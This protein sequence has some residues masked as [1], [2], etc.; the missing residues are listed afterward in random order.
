M[1]ERSKQR[2][3]RIAGRKGKNGERGAALVLT[4]IMLVLM[5]VIA[6]SVIA[7]SNSEAIVAGNDLQQTRARYA[8]I[9]GLEYMTNQFSDLFVRTSNPTAA[10]LN[11][12][13][14]TP[15]PGFVAEGYVFDQTLKVGDRPARYE[16]LP[17]D[18]R[19]YAGLYASLV[20]YKLT[21]IATHE[22]TG[23]RVTVEREINNYLIPLFQFGMFSDSDIELHP[24]PP[25]LF[26]GRVH[27]NG[28]IYVNGDVRF[29]SKVTTASE[30]VRDV[31]RNGSTR[32]GGNVRM[33]V[34]GTNVQLTRGSATNGPNFPG[35]ANGQRGYW[36]GS[37]AGNAFN[38]WDNTSI[39]P[40]TG[41]DNQ[42]NKQLLTRSTGAVPLRLPLELDGNPTREIIKRRLTGDDQTLTESR[43]H[44]K[45]QIRILLDDENI[46]GT[47][48]A[49]IPAGRGVTLS[50]F[51]PVPLGGGKSLWRID[52]NGN[53]VTTS[54]TAPKQG[55]VSGPMAN[56]VRNAKSTSSTSGSVTIPRGAGINGRILIEIVP[57]N[58]APIDVTSLALSMGMTVGEPN[59]I[60]HLQRPL[61]AAFTQG[62]RDRD[63]ESDDLVSLINS[64]MAA[65]GEIQVSST[66]PVS[67][68]TYGFLDNI[69]DDASFR[70]D[71]PVPVSTP[72]PANLNAIVPINVYNVR[73]GWPRT[74]LPINIINERGMTSVVEINMRNL[75]RWVDGVYDNN[76][77]AGTQAVS[78]NIDGQNGYVLYISDRR[79]DKIKQELNA[80]NATISTTNGMVDN[81]D[82]Y[83]P[84]GSL[85]AGEDV[86]D[87]GRDFGTGQ[88]KRGSLQKDTT[89][90]PDLGNTWSVSGTVNLVNRRNRAITNVLTWSNPNNYFRRAVRLFNGE[91]LQ[92]SGTGEKLSA[93]KGL[94]VATENM[95]YIWGNFNTT[96]INSA[97]ASGTASLNDSTRPSYYLGNQVPASIISDAFFPLSRT[98]YDGASAMF[99]EGG[100]TRPADGNLQNV[101]Q[102]TSVRAGIIAGNNLSAL[103]GSPDAGN[104]ADSRLSGGM[105]NF[106]RF[107]ENWVNTNRRW[108]FVGSFIPLYR[109]TQALGQWN[110]AAVSGTQFI[111]Y[112][113]PVRNWAFDDTFKN[114]AQLPPGTPVFQY[115]EPTGF[116]QVLNH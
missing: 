115:V 29:L 85:D 96:G 94:T 97:P 54:S 88:N 5:G 34:T 46:A 106:P 79:G 58:G 110:Y 45:A 80:A 50:T 44:S 70:E 38:T 59:A 75:V 61:W 8:A 36:P 108:N 77:L 20:P 21:T 113:A 64:G 23:T 18:S 82:I 47:N 105:H 42:F 55:S 114:P 100:D 12:I 25:F 73:E 31:L 30:L 40:A 95:V 71:A 86:I 116:R 66:P 87:W 10:Q 92:V 39:L 2:T 78:G 26:N 76:L 68:P 24:G 51:T 65:D 101:R 84:N 41:A 90:L 74:A 91:N 35:A 48:V 112:G 17:S 69:A 107:L 111:I 37:P 43:Y 13:A 62:S 60:V 67:E 19:A 7:V 83:G 15:P 81:E 109:S 56:V 28:N 63:G 102:E 27:A 93:T 103:S 33:E 89:E 52:N 22:D 16:L 14:N 72:F 32:T 104:G 98:W 57:P 99:P 11:G 1:H 4:L 49:G 9:S 53:Y 6:A 3:T